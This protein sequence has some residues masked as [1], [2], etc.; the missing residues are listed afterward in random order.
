MASIKSALLL[1]LLSA[2][3]LATPTKRSICNA[4]RKTINGQEYTVSCGMDRLGGDY[5]RQQSSW[6]DCISACGADST[7]LTAQ[8]HEDSGWCYLK[9]SVN[10]PVAS[11]GEDTVDLGSS[12]KQDMT[13]TLNGLQCTITCGVD[14]A[15]G[16]YNTI[17]SDNYLACAQACASDIHCIT[18]Q[19]NELNGQCYMK[20][21]VNAAISSTTTDTISCGRTAP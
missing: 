20:N 13:V 3:T 4:G 19:F 2:T 7:C 14:H 15:G 1:A 6:D 12:C 5:A 8:Y 10:P 21:S 17:A 16:N 9:N 11:S 18:A